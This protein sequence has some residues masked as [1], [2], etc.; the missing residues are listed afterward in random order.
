M[1]EMQKTQVQSLCWEDLLEE[2]MATHSS[3]LVW[4]IS[5]TGKPGGYSLWDY[6]VGQDWATEH[7]F[8]HW[9]VWGYWYFSWQSWFQLVTHPAWQ[10]TS[11]GNCK[12][13]F[14]QQNDFPNA[15]NLRIFRWEDYSG[16]FGWCWSAITYVFIRERQRKQC[17]TKKAVLHF[18]L[19][20]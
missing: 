3:I 2:E 16:L 18:R 19:W 5:W 12:C 6:R 4:K 7:I 8:I 1:Q 9:H 15:N 20:R 14:K 17:D 11:P 13:Y 10:G